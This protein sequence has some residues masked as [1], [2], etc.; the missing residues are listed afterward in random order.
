MFPD[1]RGVGSSERGD[2]VTDARI[3]DDEVQRVD[4]LAFDMIHCISGV[5]WGLA[6]DLHHQDFAG[7]VF[8]EGEELL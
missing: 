5:G 2:I 4:S 8:R 6:V 3:G 7:G 1:D